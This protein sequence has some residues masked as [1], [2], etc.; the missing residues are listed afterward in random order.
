MGCP[1]AFGTFC[2]IPIS[3]GIPSLSPWYASLDDCSNACFNIRRIKPVHCSGLLS[4]GPEIVNWRYAFHSHPRTS[5]CPALHHLNS[6]Q[7]GWCIPMH[8][9]IYIYMYMY[10]FIVL[11]IR[12]MY[13]I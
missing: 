11:H 6:L 5:L 10:I 7:I 1:I 4:H 13:G 12:C 3:Y 9:Y 2:R 8:I